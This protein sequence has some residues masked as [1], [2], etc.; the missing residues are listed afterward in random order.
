MADF[1]LPEAQE[2]ETHSSGRKEGEGYRNGF[3]LFFL[4]MWMLDIILF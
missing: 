1:D 4:S 3:G 2:Y